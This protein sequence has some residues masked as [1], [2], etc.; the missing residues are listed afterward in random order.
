MSLHTVGKVLGTLAQS[1]CEELSYR[2]HQRAVDLWRRISSR[3]THVKEHSISF[4]MVEDA[5]DTLRKR[6]L[7]RTWDSC[8]AEEKQTYFSFNLETAKELLHSSLLL[9]DAEWLLL[10]HGKTDD[11]IRSCLDVLSTSMLKPTV[12]Y[13][14]KPASNSCRL[15]TLALG[16]LREL[17]LL[18]LKPVEDGD[19]QYIT[20]GHTMQ[21]A[22]QLRV[23]CDFVARI[24]SERDFFVFRGLLHPLILSGDFSDNRKTLQQISNSMIT[25]GGSLET[26][27]RDIGRSCANLEA[28]GLIAKVNGNNSQSTSHNWLYYIRTEA[29]LQMSTVA[30]IEQF[31]RKRFGTT[32]LRIFRSS[33]MKDSASMEELSQSV[34]MPFDVLREFVY[35]MGKSSIEH[36]FFRDGSNRNESDPK[37]CIICSSLMMCRRFANRLSEKFVTI[38]TAIDNEHRTFI[39]RWNWKSTPQLKQMKSLTGFL[40]RKSSEPQNI[41]LISS[42]IAGVATVQVSCL[43]SQIKR[44]ESKATMEKYSFASRKGTWHS[45]AEKKV[46]DINVGDRIALTSEMLSSSKYEVGRVID[47]APSLNTFWVLWASCITKE[48]ELTAN[49]EVSSSRISK[50]DFLLHLEKKKEPFLHGILF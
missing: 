37:L 30:A 16:T 12:M 35:A 48:Q 44:Y 42:D 40:L 47:I 10:S 45:L 31:H 13:D 5:V 1:I 27:P 26:S 22:K 32:S 24:T 28:L 38:R 41:C 2:P 49:V 6:E 15:K 21:K 33:M 7:L 3:R 14:R 20:T 50:A 34:L 11:L 29:I 23:C 18:T 17:K 19:S 46:K 43:S 39:D 25:L 9:R 4:A 36:T 8:L